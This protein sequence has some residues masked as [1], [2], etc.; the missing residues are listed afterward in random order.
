MKN[1]LLLPIALAIAILNHPAASGASISVHSTGTNGS[2]V[3]PYY[4]IAASTDHGI[5]AKSPAYTDVSRAG[6]WAPAISGTNWINPSHSGS[7]GQS[8][9]IYSYTY[10]TTFDLAGLNPATA[11]LSGLLQ[12]DDEVTLFLNGTQVSSSNI[13][14]YTRTT[15]FSIGSNYSAAFLPGLNIFS[16]FVTNSGNYATGFDAAV[17]GTATS[18]TPEGGSF[19]MI[20][21]AGIILTG[22]GIHRKRHPVTA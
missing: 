5:T 11:T 6:G 13:G 7:G 18:E 21:L 22:A 16:F 8:F 19:A 12:A 15:P 10:S 4:T 3:D 1:S 14:T 9:G 2:G 17:S 20:S